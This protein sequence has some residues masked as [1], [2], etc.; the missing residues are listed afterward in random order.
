MSNPQPQILFDLVRSNNGLVKQRIL[1]VDQT[2]SRVWFVRA[3]SGH[4]IILVTHEKLV[5]FG[6]YQE[7]DIVSVVETN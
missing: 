1:G 2:W 4:D 6:G 7:L 3:R 5:E